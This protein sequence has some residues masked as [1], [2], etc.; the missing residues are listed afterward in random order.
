MK[1]AGYS[2]F[3]FYL[4]K[5]LKNL[6]FFL[7]REGKSRKKGKLWCKNVKKALTTSRRP[8]TE[9]TFVLCRNSC[10]AGS[11]EPSIDNIGGQIRTV[12][13]SK[14]T[15]ATSG[16]NVSQ[17]DWKEIFLAKYLHTLIL[18]RINCTQTLEY[19]IYF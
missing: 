1:K 5:N 12:T 11:P 16:P 13:A 10:T 7:N 3:K 18:A 4:V 6:S 8:F 17:T 19:Y 15:F 9:V 2:N 14:I